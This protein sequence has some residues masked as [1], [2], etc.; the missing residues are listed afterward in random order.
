VKIITLEDPIEYKLPGVVQTQVGPGYTFA[1]G[2]RSI[3][4]QDPDVIMV[5]EIRDHE[6]AET[7]VHAALTGHLVFSTLHTNSAAGAFARLINLGVEPHMVG[8]AFNIV[9]GQRLVRKLCEHCK[10]ARDAT[11]EEQRLIARVMDQ[12]VALQTINE[13]KGCEKCSMSGYKGRIGVFE[14]IRIDDAVEEVV[15]RDPRDV[16]ILEASRGQNIP[17]MQQDGVMK[18]LAGITSLDELERV[19]DLHNM[20]LPEL[21]PEDVA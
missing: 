20:N 18:A 21:K 7:A 3:L 15:I 5:G 10:V 8:S 17:N 9:L 13:A 2:L 4:R 6:V 12:P 11:T 19:L 1:N 14:A 16:S